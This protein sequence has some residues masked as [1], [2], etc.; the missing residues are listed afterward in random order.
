MA[1]TVR[2]LKK[3]VTKVFLNVTLKV[4][5]VMFIGLLI[6]QLFNGV[7]KAISTKS[8][9]HERS[10]TFREMR[11]KEIEKKRQSIIQSLDDYQIALDKSH[12]GMLEDGEVRIIVN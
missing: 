2:I 12:G 5:L 9:I 8:V 11:D 1:E 6:F 7:I 4:I 3:F 10:E